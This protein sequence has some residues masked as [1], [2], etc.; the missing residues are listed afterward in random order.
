[1]SDR[2]TI[3]QIIAEELARPAVQKSLADA[4]AKSLASRIWEALRHPIVLT[5]AGFLLTAT[6]GTHLERIFSRSEEDRRLRDLAIAAAEAAEDEVRASL[7][8]LTQLTHE[9][10]VRADLLRS[11]IRRDA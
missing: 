9:R 2:E 11:A 5:I 7:L 4:A 10:S 8:A 1:M 6:V 3:R